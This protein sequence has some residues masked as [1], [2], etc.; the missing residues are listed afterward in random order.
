[1]ASDDERTYEMLWDCEFCGSRAL[2]G[3]SHR[4]CPACGAPQDP[5]SRYFPD[6]E[7]KVAVEDHAF[8]GV[9]R[10]CANCDAPSGAAAEFCGGCGAALG[11]DDRDVGRVADAVVGAE[12]APVAPTSPPER[13]TPSRARWPWVVGLA[14]V[15][16]AAVSATLLWT[17][18]DTAQVTGHQWSR[19][20][21]VEQFRTVAEAAW[22]DALPGDAREVRRGRKQRSTR[23]VA[24]GETCT[25]TNVDQGDGT[26]RQVR[27]CEP[28]YR[29]E[30]V[31]DAWCDFAVDRWVKAR[32]IV[33]SGAAVEPSPHW[34]EVAVK[35]C[36]RLGCE[37][38]GGRREAYTVLLATQDGD[39]GTAR[40][41]CG[42]GQ[43]RWK[44]FAVASR[45]EAQIGVLTGSL[46]CD[47][48]AVAR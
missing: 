15:V 35:E 13:A 43:D 1:V 34:P 27:R 41:E 48:L 47:S 6:E 33:A 11:D 40:H 19:V 18:T 28:R 10:V 45:F 12:P 36:A 20:V 23:R 14:A 16:V 21:D 17:R 3:I 25:T 46:D 8:V 9:D 22:C 37:R 29:D 30:P 26:F 31:Y 39:S 7:H 5:E 4:H 32:E 2:L 24:D 38:P 44:T 42:F